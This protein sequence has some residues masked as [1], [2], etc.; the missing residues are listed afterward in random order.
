MCNP[1][2]A[3]QIIAAE[4]RVAYLEHWSQSR[5][6]RTTAE[7]CRAELPMATAELKR[8]RDLA[9][10]FDDR[11]CLYHRMREIN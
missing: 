1:K 11:A 8:L 4:A 5:W 3:E 2:L 9:P 7:R 6:Y 10:E